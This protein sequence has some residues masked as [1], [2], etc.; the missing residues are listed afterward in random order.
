MGAW[1][2]G[3]EGGIQ[4]RWWQASSSREPQFLQ[5]CV[6]WWGGWRSSRGVGG[7]APLLWLLAHTL[8][9]DGKRDVA[10]SPTP[11]FPLDWM[12]LSNV[13]SAFSEG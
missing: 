1:K 3:W 11:G 13:S 6:S 12:L 4:G 2:L 10:P 5:C 9:T 8:D 7:G